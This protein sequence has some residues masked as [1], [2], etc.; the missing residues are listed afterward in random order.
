MQQTFVLLDLRS[1]ARS[2][3]VG[4]FTGAYLYIC[5]NWFHVHYD[6]GFSSLR[7]PHFKG[8]SRLHITSQVA[9]R[10]VLGQPDCLRLDWRVWLCLWLLSQA[11]LM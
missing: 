1:P 10:N 4:D 9:V 2:T 5:V 8:F 11:P 7:I 6:E 3:M